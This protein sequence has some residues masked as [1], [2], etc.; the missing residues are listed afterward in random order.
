MLL[1]SRTNAILHDM[2]AMWECTGGGI[3]QPS[4]SDDATGA[5]V[6]ITDMRADWS[7]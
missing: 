6:K 2:T 3:L 4:T 7:A 5:G 1:L